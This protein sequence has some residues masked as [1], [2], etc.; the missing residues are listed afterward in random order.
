MQNIFL[1]HHKNFYIF[2]KNSYKMSLGTK[3]KTI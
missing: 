3:V 2:D 1:Q